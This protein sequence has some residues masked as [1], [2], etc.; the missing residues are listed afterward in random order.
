[1]LAHAGQFPMQL[2]HIGAAVLNQTPLAWDANRANILA[3]IGEARDRSISILCLPELCI[4]GYGCEDA[5]LSHGVQQMAL[6][7]LDEVLPETHGM[8][9]SLG[10]PLLYQKALCDVACLAVDG[11]MAGFTAKRYL[12]GDG[13][14]YEP[15]WFKPWPAGHRAQI[16]IHGREYPLGDIHFDCGGVKIGFEICEDAWVANRPGA[17]LALRSVDMILN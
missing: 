11:R 4:S 14:H 10:L 5:F 8:I 3:A 15:R 16:S 12:A 13:I 9:V 1:M 7:V 6:R 2:I 17:D